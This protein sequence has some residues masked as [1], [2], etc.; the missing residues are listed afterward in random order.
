MEPRIS[1]GHILSDGT[2]IV[3]VAWK[4]MPYWKAEGGLRI[5]SR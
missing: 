4:E 2:I 1:S 3:D 5:E